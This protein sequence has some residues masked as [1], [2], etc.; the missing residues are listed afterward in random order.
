MIT[1][2][3]DEARDHVN[4]ATAE[5]RG[6]EDFVPFL[7]CRAD[8]RPVFAPI[9][10]SEDARDVAANLM[11]AIC[12]AHR[13]KEAV[14]GAVSWTVDP[15]ANADLSIRPS[16][17][18]HRMEIVCLAHFG[19]LGEATYTAKVKRKAGRVLLDDWEAHTASGAPSRFGDAI[20]LGMEMG[21]NIS[22]EV[23]DCFKTTLASDK[24]WRAAWMVAD[25]R[26]S[27]QNAA[28]SKN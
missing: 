2:L 4:K 14:F 10:I 11:T 23:A 12:A 22:A 1:R 6:D 17:N 20:R 8:D 5:L 18:P 27:R 26:T 13:A 15:N 3:I 28:A 7:V 21:R 25:L 24:P 9:E 16:L 19:P